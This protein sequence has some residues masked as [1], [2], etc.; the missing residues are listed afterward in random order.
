M[1]YY[2]ERIDDPAFGVG[3]TSESYS[4]DLLSEG[5]YYSDWDTVPFYLR[6]GGFAD[7]QT[8]DLDWPLCSAKLK[9]IIETSAS[10]LDRIQWLSAKVIS[11]DRTEREY[12]ILHLPERVDAIDRQK[13]SR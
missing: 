4:F 2:L 9:A 1:Y 5:E 11:I 6:D 7:Y 8:N 13:S 12:F 10:P 3:Y